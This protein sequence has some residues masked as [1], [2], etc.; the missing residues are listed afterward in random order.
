VD[1]FSKLEK[2]FRCNIDVERDIDIQK[3]TYINGKDLQLRRADFED[4]F[5][6]VEKTF[7]SNTYVKRDLDIQKKNLQQGTLPL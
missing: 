4:Q 7:R 5:L 6:N 2:T 3:K 1:L